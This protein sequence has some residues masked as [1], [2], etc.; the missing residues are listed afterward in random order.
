MICQGCGQEFDRDEAIEK[1]DHYYSESSGWTYEDV[2]D[3]PLCF[4]CATDYADE[5]WLSGNLIDES[6]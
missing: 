3:E 2:I 5:Q 4:H 1:F 6:N